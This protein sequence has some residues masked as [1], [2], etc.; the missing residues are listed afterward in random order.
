MGK[1]RADYH[2]NDLSDYLTQT[3]LNPTREAALQ[4]MWSLNTARK[5]AR[6]IET[7]YCRV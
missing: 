6:K 4:V 2:E 3:W 7:Q 1:T 5:F